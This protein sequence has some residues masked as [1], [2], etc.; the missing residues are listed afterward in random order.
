MAGVRFEDF[1]GC[2]FFYGFFAFCFG[3]AF[4][5]LAVNLGFIVATEGVME[6]A[7]LPLSPLTMSPFLEQNQDL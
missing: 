7:L 5:S 3:A 2:A 6:F 4:F 1:L